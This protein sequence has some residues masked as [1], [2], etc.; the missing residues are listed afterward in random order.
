MAT[1]VAVFNDSGGAGDRVDPRHWV[2]NVYNAPAFVSRTARCG[3]RCPAGIGISR[4]FEIS[5]A[6][7]I[8]FRFDVI[9]LLDETYLL[10]R[11]ASIGAFAPPTA[12]AAL[13]TPALARNFNGARLADLRPRAL[14]K[15]PCASSPL[16]TRGQL[17][18]I[19]QLRVGPN[20]D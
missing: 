15:A 7:T 13:F 20:C 19:V 4:R 8:K 12:R 2:K 10:R 16:G 3:P 18:R 14:T 1:F 9:K 11:S 5:G 6:D 17:R